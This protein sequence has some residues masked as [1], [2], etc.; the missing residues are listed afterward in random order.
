MS[1]AAL[2]EL[3]NAF[4]LTGIRELMPHGEERLHKAVNCPILL[5]HCYRLQTNAER[6]IS[7]RLYGVSSKAEGD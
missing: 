3:R 4:K 6:V 2:R 1:R 5:A 7:L